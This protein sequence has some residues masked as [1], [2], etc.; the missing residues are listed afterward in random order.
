MQV[1]IVIHGGLIIPSTSFKGK[2]KLLQKPQPEL[3]DSKGPVWKSSLCL[4][5]WAL[6]FTRQDSNSFTSHKVR[7]SPEAVQP[8]H[9]I[10]LPHIE[11]KKAKP[12]LNHRL[13]T[14]L[15]K[16]PLIGSASLLQSAEERS[17]GEWRAIEHPTQQGAASCFACLVQ[18]CNQRFSVSPRLL[19]TAKQALASLNLTAHLLNY[20]P[21]WWE[22]QGAKEEISYSENT[23][24]R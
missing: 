23:T 3:Q 24:E 7:L 4:P 17:L 1:Q 6:W 16:W 18:C 10:C 13:V 15:G 11:H 5:S 8:W 12:F 20:V 9:F 19:R 21:N 14:E 2:T 22:K